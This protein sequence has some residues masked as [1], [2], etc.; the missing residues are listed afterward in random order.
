L[1]MW[2]RFDPGFH[3]VL[4]A[5]PDG[6]AALPITPRCL[7]PGEPAQSCALTAAQACVSMALDQLR[8]THEQRM[9]FTPRP[10]ALEHGLTLEGVRLPPSARPGERVLID[11]EWHAAQPLPGDYHLFVHVVDMAGTLVA[12]YD[13]V[14]GENTF[15]TT[16]W[17]HPQR[18]SQTAMVELP[19]SLPAG[20]YDVYV[21]WYRFPD[22]TRLAVNSAVKGA[23]SQLVFIG[24]LVIP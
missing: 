4:L 20:I 3:T 9:P 15:P 1:V 16:L 19:A 22:I 5:A 7:L 13:A 2:Q 24:S 21:G 12:Q 6:C 14:P 8:I 18:W 23:A 10:A 11:T 17:A